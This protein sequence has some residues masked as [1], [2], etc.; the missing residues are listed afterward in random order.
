MESGEFKVDHE[1]ARA[2]IARVRRNDADECP[3]DPLYA[4]AESELLALENAL[5]NAPAPGL[6]AGVPEGWWCAQIS[7]ARLNDWCAALYRGPEPGKAGLTYNDRVAGYGPTPE[8]AV[9][10]AASKTGASRE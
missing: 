1:R 4:I 3:E 10:D 8:A 5:L 2:I 9:Q 7:Q 6:I